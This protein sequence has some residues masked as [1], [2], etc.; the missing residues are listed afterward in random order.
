MGKK[1]EYNQPQPPITQVELN[2]AIKK[3]KKGKRCGPDDIPNDVFIMADDQTRQIYLTTL[4]QT[5]Q[6][7]NIPPHWQLGKGKCS[8]E[9]G[10]TVS[11]NF[12]KL[13]ERIINERAKQATNI[14]DPKQ[15]AKKKDQPLT[16]CLY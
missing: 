5:L 11:S 4:N 7:Q 8:N 2:Q 3:L 9:R 10:I 16:T 15:E 1:E 13:F 12:G 6:T 14:S